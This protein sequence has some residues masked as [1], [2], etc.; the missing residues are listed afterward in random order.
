M[1]PPS[2]PAIGKETGSLS[3]SRRSQITHQRIEAGQYA[4]AEQN[5]KCNRS[6]AQ[7]CF[8]RRDLL[9]IQ[10]YREEKKHRLNGSPDFP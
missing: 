10:S 5:R 2:M 9:L 3:Q 7:L 4:D 6:P 8:V 1:P